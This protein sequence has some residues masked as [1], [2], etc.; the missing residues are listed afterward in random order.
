MGLSLPLPKIKYRNA[1]VTIVSAT[2]DS[3]FSS[4]TTGMLWFFLLIYFGFSHFA[5][6]NIATTKKK[7]KQKNHKPTNKQTK[8][9]TTKKP[10]WN[11]LFWSNHEIVFKDIL[12][13]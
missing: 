5:V 13:K 8:K 4:K 12:M 9:N 1:A 3:E 11:S 7:P 2:F 6:K 10:L